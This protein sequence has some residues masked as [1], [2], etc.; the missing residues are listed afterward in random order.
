MVNL[1]EHIR[2]EE[3][4]IAQQERATG[5]V[6]QEAQKGINRLKSAVQ[7]GVQKT[8]VNI[9]DARVKDHEG[10]IAGQYKVGTES[11]ASGIS[12]DGDLVESVQ[13]GGEK[14]EVLKEVIVHEIGH[15]LDDR[16]QESQ[17]INFGHVSEHDGIEGINQLWTERKMGESSETYNQETQ[18]VTNFVTATG[19]SL[20]LIHI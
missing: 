16:R 17:I 18:M 10:N 5:E 8:G 19:K 20:S 14:V 2:Q 9:S 12:I 13:Y 4:S 7:F 11:V 1:S 6:N 3:E 15:L